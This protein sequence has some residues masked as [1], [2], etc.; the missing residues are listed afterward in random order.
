[1]TSITIAMASAKRKRAAMIYSVSARW[2]AKTRARALTLFR[3][4][5]WAREAGSS[6]RAGRRPFSITGVSAGIHGEAAG[7]ASDRA[8][9]AQLL[10]L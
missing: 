6:G 5:N 7:G 3:S 4:R 10:G 8:G 1:M 9:E 2:M